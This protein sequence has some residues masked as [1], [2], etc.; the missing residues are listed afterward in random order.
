MNKTDNITY[1][2]LSYMF[3]SM[4]DVYDKTSV[5]ISEGS[6][7]LPY[8]QTNKLAWQSFR[9]ISR[10][11]KT[12]G[13]ETESSLLLIEIKISRASAFALTSQA[14]ISKS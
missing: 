8:L 14:L 6:E 3:F 10:R 2:N 5:K 7:I 1:E 12:S 4:A 9:D 13:S 11:S